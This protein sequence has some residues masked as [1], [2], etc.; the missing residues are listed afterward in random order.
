MWRDLAAP[1]SHALAGSR[2]QCRNRVFRALA[3]EAL[4]EVEQ[5]DSCVSP[6]LSLEQ[7]KVVNKETGTKTIG[8]VATSFSK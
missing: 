2:K 5:N 3:D 8:S 7:I 6:N 1:G 4:K